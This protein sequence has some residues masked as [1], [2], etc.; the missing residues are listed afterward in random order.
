MTDVAKLEEKVREFAQMMKI[1]DPFSMRSWLIGNVSPTAVASVA[2]LTN[3][4]PHPIRSTEIARRRG[5]EGVEQFE[6]KFFGRSALTV[7]TSWSDT[8]MVWKIVS[9]NVAK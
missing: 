8:G 3:A 7:Q 9:M 6:V 5:G 4:L 1:G 2:A